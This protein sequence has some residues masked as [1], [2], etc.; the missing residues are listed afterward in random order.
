[1]EECNLQFTYRARYYR[2]GIIGA[3]TRQ[4]WFVLHGYG[5]LAGYFIRK[6]S[7]L[8]N[9][10]VCVIAPEGLSRFYLQDVTA[11]RQSGNDRVG[12]TW[13]T[14]ENRQTD[15]DNYLEYLTKMYDQEIPRNTAIPVTVLGFSQ[16]AA[17]ASRWVMENR[18]AFDRLILWSGVFP[19]DLKFSADQNGLRG[20]E[21]IF[22]YGDSDPFI[23]AEHFTEMEA[24]SAKLGINPARITFRGG[25]DIDQETLLTLA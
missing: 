2:S 7:A 17:T 8:E 14:K 5:Q 15:I 19:P 3:D 21:T 16:G 11:R 18:I 24:L 23:T 12:A 22:V 9:K 10:G 25:H 4:I 13:M 6:F 1:M 20:K